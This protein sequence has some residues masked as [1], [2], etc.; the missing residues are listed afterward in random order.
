MH[1][2]SVE[3]EQQALL[4]D[5]QEINQFIKEESEKRNIKILNLAKTLYRSS[6]KRRGK[7]RKTVWRLAEETLPDGVHL[8]TE[9]KDRWAKI[10]ATCIKT[11]L[12]ETKTEVTP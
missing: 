4:N 9:L 10:I 7:E 1:L 5:L 8:N 2:P 3:S 6:R 11:F 12:N